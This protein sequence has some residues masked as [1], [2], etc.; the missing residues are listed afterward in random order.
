MRSFILF[1][2]LYSGVAFG[3]KFELTAKGFVNSEDT[4]KDYIV[5]EF[6]EKTKEELY[7]QVLI[8]LNKKYKSAK[9]VISSVEP[10]NITLNAISASRIRRTN[11]HSFENKYNITLSFKD[12]KIKIDAPQV[13]L[14]T[15]DYGKKQ[16]MY[17]VGGFSLDGSSFGIFNKKGDV[18]IEK[19]KEDLESFANS[20]IEDIKNGINSKDEW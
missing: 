14:Y 15:F 2:L 9:N 18:K 12:G 11:S 6:P 20:F 4:S 8:T 1:L 16:E 10:E 5:V 7:K 3:Q 19:A 13:D 17:L